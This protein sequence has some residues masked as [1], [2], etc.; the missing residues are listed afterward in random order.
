MKTALDRVLE[1]TRLITH[2]QAGRIAGWQGHFGALK[3]GS[4]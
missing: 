3:L 1:Q 2:L 4:Y